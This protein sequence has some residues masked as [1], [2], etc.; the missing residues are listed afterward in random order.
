MLPWLAAVA[1]MVDNVCCGRPSRL[2]LGGVEADLAGAG[3]RLRRS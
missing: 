2:Q 1:T 3:R